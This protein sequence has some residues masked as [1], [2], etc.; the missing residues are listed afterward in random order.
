MVHVNN[1]NK[2]LEVFDLFVKLEI[3]PTA[4]KRDVVHSSVDRLH[5]VHTDLGKRNEL[6][7]R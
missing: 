6:I 4:Q 7:G 2:Q 3:K 1:I 5:I